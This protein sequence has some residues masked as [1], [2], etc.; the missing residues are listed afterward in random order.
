MLI[1]S[2]RKSKGTSREFRATMELSRSHSTCRMCI[3]IA[4]FN[5]W[6]YNY[7]HDLEAQNPFH[8]INA[9]TLAEYGKSTSPDK[10]IL[11]VRERGTFWFHLI[12][13][14]ARTPLEFRK[15]VY[16]KFSPFSE[17]WTQHLVRK[18]ALEEIKEVT[19][20]ADFKALKNYDEL[21]VILFWY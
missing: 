11:R 17:H 15:Q 5:R 6:R 21:E 10:L 1:D 8:E 3:R 2:P 13:L 19:T 20:E 12:Y 14:S 7:T 16:D 9:A 4:D 18:S